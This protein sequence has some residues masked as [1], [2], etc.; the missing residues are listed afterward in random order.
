MNQTRITEHMDDGSRGRAALRA[1]PCSYE[2]S[3]RIT[4]RVAATAQLLRPSRETHNAACCGYGAAATSLP[5]SRC[6]APSALPPS[7]CRAPAAHPP[8]RCR[9]S[10][11]VPLPRPSCC[12]GAV[13]CGA[14]QCA[15][16]RRG[17]A[18][19]SR[20]CA[21]RLG[22]AQRSVRG[23]VRRMRCSAARLGAARCG[24][25]WCNALQ[26]RGGAANAIRRGA[27][28]CGPAWPGIRGP[29]FESEYGTP[30]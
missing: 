7:P 25:V 24:A 27:A 14:L 9:T 29:A 16:V 10:P 22:A 1:G 12:P 11:T 23:A 15:A 20:C 6:R 5:L 8:Y 13:R 28:R 21:V 18:R 19:H 30:P 3:G 17:P 26:R 4:L 2:Q